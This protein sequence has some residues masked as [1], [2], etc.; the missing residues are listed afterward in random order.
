MNTRPII[1]VI[2]AKRYNSAQSKELYCGSWWVSKGAWHDLSIMQTP[3]GDLYFLD[4]QERRIDPISRR[5]AIWHLRH[6]SQYG[7][8][9]T[10]ALRMH[11]GVKHWEA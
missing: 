8:N 1:R 6:E 5:R 2:G 3:K 10:D 4:W 11:F 7:D 9:A